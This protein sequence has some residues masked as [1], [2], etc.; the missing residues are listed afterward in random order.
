MEEGL[1]INVFYGETYIKLSRNSTFYDLKKK[2]LFEHKKLVKY[3]FYQKS[4]INE[5]LLCLNYPTF[6][7]IIDNND[8]VEYRSGQFRCKKCRKYLNLTSW[9]C[10]HS[11][12]CRAYHLLYKKDKNT[13]DLLSG[14]KEIPE[15]EENKDINYESMDEE[16][17]KT[18]NAV[19]E[20]E[21]IRKLNLIN[22][23]LYN[24]A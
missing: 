3:F 2:I 23:L 15:D 11:N 5:S 17:N 21:R 6:R 1:E 10:K 20:R 14:Y 19:L 13:L 24:N 9:N 7:T 18:I 12:S 16:I 4:K 22:S 8:F